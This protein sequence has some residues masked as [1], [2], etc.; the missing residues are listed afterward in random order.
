MAIDI[1]IKNIFYTY[2]LRWLKTVLRAVL[3]G[4]RQTNMAAKKAV[5]HNTISQNLLF[6]I[7]LYLAEFLLL[8]SFK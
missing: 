7:L 1:F 4:I 5:V 8:S 6:K 3:S 2:V